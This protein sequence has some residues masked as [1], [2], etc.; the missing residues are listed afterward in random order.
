MHL[1]HYSCYTGLCLCPE[2]EWQK[3]RTDRESDDSLELVSLSDRNPITSP[4]APAALLVVSWRISSW[5]LAL[6]LLHYNNN[7]C[8]L[9]TWGE[10]QLL[11]THMSRMMMII[12]MMPHAFHWFPFTLF[13]LLS[14]LIDRLA[15]VNTND[16]LLCSWH[17]SILLSRTV[18]SSSCCAVVVILSR[19]EWVITVSLFSYSDPCCTNLTVALFRRQKFVHI[20][21]I[22]R[23]ES[24]RIHNFWLEHCETRVLVEQTHSWKQS[25]WME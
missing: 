5:N 17:L 6:S 18:A 22:T 24:H 13:P 16:F 11:P 14:L 23:R 2:T 21:W 1:Y 4:S 20:N 3:G 19:R 9:W 7:S 8:L 12:M 10:F 25:N 15:S